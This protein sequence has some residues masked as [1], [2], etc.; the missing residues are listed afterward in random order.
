[1]KHRYYSA[2]LVLILTVVMTAPALAHD[3]RG[4]QS[5]YEAGSLAAMAASIAGPG[6][7]TTQAT[8][9]DETGPVHKDEHQHGGTGGH[10]AASSQNVELVGKVN[11]TGVPGGISDV[12]AFNGYAYLGA[13][14]SECTGRSAASQGG[15][16][17]VV[18]IK[19]P[20][21]PKVVGKI[22]SHP[23]TYVGEGVFV[24]H[25]ETKF[26]T[27]DVLLHNNEA[28][29]ASK[30][31]VGGASIWDVTNPLSPKL[32]A[33]N[34]GDINPVNGK[35]NLIHSVQGWT[36][37]NKAYAA[38]VDNMETKDVD[39][40]DITDPR[41]PKLISE[42]GLEDWPGAQGSYANGD[43]VFH[44]DMQVKFIRGH[45]YMQVSYWDAGYITLNVD[46]PAKPV[47]VEDSDYLGP[48]PLTGF[49]PQEGNGHQSYWSSNNKYILGTDEDFSPYRTSFKV[50]TGP[51]AGGYG[52]GEFG[53][54]VPLAQKHP[55]GLTGV[56]VWAGSG[57]DEDLNG[58]G[59]SDRA[60][61]PP[62]SS[63]SAASGELKIAV[64]SRGVCFFSKKVE[65]GEVAGYDAVIVGNSHGGSRSGF[66]P[67]AF[68]CGSKG[69]TYD[70]KISAICTG[71]RAM[72]LLFDDAPAYAAP[73]GYAAGGDMPALGTVGHKI[74]ASTE[75]DGW[76][77]VHLFDAD[78][79]KE[80]DAY[81]VEES[82]DP[83]FASG[84][85]NLTVHEVKTDP[86]DDVNLAYLSYYDAGLRV[87]GFGPNGI[88]ERGHYIA[89]GGNDF[90]G[91]YPVAQGD[92][93]PLLLM[94]DR[95]SGLWIFRYTGP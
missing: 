59:V 84:Y 72:H 83:A 58:N 16:V 91:T 13:F 6:E 24:M 64:F 82:L 69:H 15:G 89:E 20:A 39:I 43:S 14:S 7:P 41:N 51:N 40:L 73:E 53:W 95:D 28:C 60:D 68:T 87:V 57:C 49:E 19:D 62:A 36:V 71:H 8:D 66:V 31:Y 65:A 45:W 4:K 42:R 3:Q 67:D 33:E 1:M 30:P 54:T 22:P 52:A 70:P 79:L 9:Q 61:V 32:L 5:G 35:A 92:G 77:Y 44:H 2:L 50:T 90:W 37:R 75:F 63:I 81:A 38:L 55:N 78:T 93:A 76:G 11:L 88:E 56:T 74:S 10:L 21:N 94:S 25:M 85:G 17:H 29:N 34:A 12:A 47:F 86:R 18:D 80:I 48:D 23:N 46:D 26:F 27:G